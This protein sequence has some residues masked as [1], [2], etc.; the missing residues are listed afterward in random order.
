MSLNAFEQA[1]KSKLRFTYKGSLSVEDLWDLKVQDLDAI[2]RQ[3]NGELKAANED[4]LLQK[5][6]AASETLA[7]KVEI[8]KRVV[9]VKLEEENERKGKAERQAQKARIIEILAEK[10]N[11]G[12]KGKSEEELRKMLDNL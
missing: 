4:S 9:T 3:C 7:L 5:P 8:V 12:L 2:Y 10:Q 6:T 1:S 11:E